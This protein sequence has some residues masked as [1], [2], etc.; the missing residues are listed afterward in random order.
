[1]EE[2]EEQVEEEEQGM[3]IMRR[4]RKSK[5]MRMRTRMGR[6][7]GMMRMRGERRM[8]LNILAVELHTLQRNCARHRCKEERRNPPQSD[9]TGEGFLLS[10]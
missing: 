6:R 3:R 8:S 7:R 10:F 1:M 4:M 9:Q 5:R 2:G